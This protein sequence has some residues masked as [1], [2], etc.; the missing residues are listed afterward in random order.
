VRD[1]GDL[2]KPQLGDDRIQVT[3]LIGGGIRVIRT[4]PPEK[5]KCDDSARRRKVREQAVV[6]VYVVREPVHQNDRRFRPRMVADVDLVSVPLHKSLL[7][8]HH[9]LWKQ[10]H[11]RTI[12]LPL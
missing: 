4:A 9:S 3:D 1:E 6:E 8:D 12:R 5:I 10:C 7:V 11:L 2:L